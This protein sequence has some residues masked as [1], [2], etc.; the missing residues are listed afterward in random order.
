MKE[1]SPAP[2]EKEGESIAGKRGRSGARG[3]RFYLKNR[4][5]IEKERAGRKGKG[6]GGKLKEK[7]SGYL[8]GAT[9]SA[10]IFLF[11]KKGL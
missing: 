4:L 1:A 2:A 6:P 10:S 3:D 11:T 8:P 7:T 9:E 5:E